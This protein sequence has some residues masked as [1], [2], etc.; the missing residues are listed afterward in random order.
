LYSLIYET[1]G[2]SELNRLAQK[3]AGNLYAKWANK[4]KTQG[5]LLVA[6]R[7]YEKASWVC[8]KAG[9]HHRE[10]EYKNKAIEVYRQYK[11]H[12]LKE[13]NNKPLSD[14]LIEALQVDIDR[15]SYRSLGQKII[16][17]LENI[18]DRFLSP[19]YQFTQK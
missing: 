3:K 19:F 6:A 15:L 9:E 5:H 4:E 12:L 11:E 2:S 18:K 8:K 10:I 7:F 16:Q 1:Q 13:K 14:Q 17:S